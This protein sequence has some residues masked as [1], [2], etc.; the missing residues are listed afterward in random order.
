VATTDHRG[1]AVFTAR[2]SG[3]GQGAVFVGGPGSLQGARLRLWAEPCA[4]EHVG[5]AAALDLPE[6]DQHLLRQLFGPGYGRLRLHRHFGAGR[7]GA[8][9]LLVEPFR[10]D[11]GDGER[12]AQPCIVK[13]G[14]RLALREDW[15]RHERWVKDLLP[16]NVSRCERFT[17]WN[18]RAALRMGLAAGQDW[19]R[20]REACEWLTTAS[21]FEAHLL[22]ERVFVGDLASCWYTNA[23]RRAPSEALARSYGRI[24]PPLLLVEDEAPP[25]GLLSRRPAGAFARAADGLLP[26]GLRSFG[27]GEEV[28]LDGLT[29]AGSRPCAGGW[30]YEL[31]L[32]DQPLRVAF[33]TPLPPELID[34]EGS[35]ERL[36]KGAEP[37]A[38]RG[39]VAGVAYDQLSAAL[40]NCVE[41]FGA[42]HPGE[43]L[44]LSEDGAW[45]LAGGRRL[46]SP[47]P[48]LHGL[49][50]REVPYQA[51]I[52]HGDLHGR[53][54]IVGHQGQPFYI[55]FGKTGPGPTLFD[56][57]KY[58][59]YLWHDNYAGWPQGAPPAECDLA[60]ALGLLDDFSAA[61]P[62][63]RFPSPYALLP[64][65]AGRSDWQTCFAQCL[66]TL[67]SAAR[68]YILA[69][70][71]EDYFIPLCLAA[72][73]MLRW[74]DPGSERTASEA[75]QA[76]R[77]GVVHALVASTLLANGVVPSV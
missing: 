11:G 36:L 26:P 69:P 13:L 38:L 25:R 75:R 28:M 34:P 20:A 65:A 74:C 8:R 47:L 55:D 48:H 21:A 40:R 61:D 71:D 18:G 5:G 45:L 16:V 39:R 14:P 12:R 29:V 67:R 68:P 42:D 30:E 1:R 60:G 37:W 76:A 64:F 27:P 70:D 52:V 56:F 57:I 51:S 10:R 9:V 33:R 66:A 22:L 31:R 73:L 59:V 32:L 72:A 53:N 62:W 44:A 46:P 49:L 7:S 19:A 43:E 54:V 63:R 6:G 41:R 77:R 17:A 35:P 2:A 15:E 50:F 23:A 58:E 3:P 24:V 4:I